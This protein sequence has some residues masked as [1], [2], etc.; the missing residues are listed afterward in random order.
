MTQQVELL[1]KENTVIIINS[2]E[3]ENKCEAENVE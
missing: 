1:S 3:L 2:K